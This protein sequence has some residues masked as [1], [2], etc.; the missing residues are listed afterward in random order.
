MSKEKFNR[1][2]AIAQAVCVVMF[3][4][5]FLG[6]TI[7][8][9]KYDLTELKYGI[10]LPLIWALGLVPYITYT[11]AVP[12]FIEKILKIDIEK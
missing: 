6:S 9:R 5:C 2:M 3:W 12:F 10:L 4:A 11:T 8:F 1:I 7:L